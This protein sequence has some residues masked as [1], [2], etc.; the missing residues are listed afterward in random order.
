[1]KASANDTPVSAFCSGYKGGG[2]PEL[3]LERQQ[4]SRRVW[5][6]VVS[7]LHPDEELAPVAGLG[8]DKTAEELLQLLVGPLRLPI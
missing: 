6:C 1:M 2:E 7:I 8:G 3:I 5:Q 4:S